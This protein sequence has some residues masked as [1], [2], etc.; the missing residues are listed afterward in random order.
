MQTK[1][2]K[3]PL[4]PRLGDDTVSQ[5]SN[6]PSLSPT[7]RSGRPGF[8]KMRSSEYE[9]RGLNESNVEGL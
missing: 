3:T 8:Q 7:K 6:A 4:N 2:I 5:I 9:L 1:S